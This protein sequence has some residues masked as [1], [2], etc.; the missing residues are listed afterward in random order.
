MLLSRIE[1]FLTVAEHKSLE[2]SK[3]VERVWGGND[4][5][6][7]ALRLGGAGSICIAILYPKLLHFKSFGLSR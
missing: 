1:L 7:Q 4:A 2:Q 5:N 3:R 6:Y